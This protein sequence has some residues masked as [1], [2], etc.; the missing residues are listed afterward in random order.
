M[1]IV[2]DCI[3]LDPARG[4][5][6]RASVGRGLLLAGCSSLTLMF[7]LFSSSNAQA[8]CRW[9]GGTGSWFDASKWDDEPGRPCSGVPTSSDWVEIDRA[10]SNITIEGGQA[11]DH[12][13]HFRGG[14]VSIVNGGVLNSN[15]SY[16]LVGQGSDRQAELVVSGADSAWNVLGEAWVGRTA[17]GK[18]RLTDGGLLNFIGGDTLV[19][20]YT[21]TMQSPSH[22]VLVIGSDADANPA[23]P[24][25]VV[26]PRVEMG[27]GD[28]GGRNAT[29]LIVF[30]HTDDGGAYIFA[31]D[32]AGTGDIEHHAGATTLTGA[33][34]YDG[35]FDIAGGTVTFRGDG[36]N[37]YTGTTTV[38][39]GAVLN[40]DK[41]DDTIAISGPVLID[42]GSVNANARN[43]F[44][45]AAII[46]LAS[47]GMFTVQNRQH[48]AG[49]EG[50]DT[51]AR[52][53][54]NE[55]LYLWDGSH[56]YAGRLEG[57]G[58]LFLRGGA[59]T[60]LGDAG[61]WAGQI[62][63]G[64]ALLGLGHERA[65]GERSLFIIGNATLQLAAD[66]MTINN[67]ITG[68][69]I[70]PALTFDSNGYDGVWSGVI[71]N[72][73]A[74]PGIRG[75]GLTKSGTGTLTLTNNNTYEGATIVTE[76]ALIV[77]GS[78]A[79]SSLV[80]VNSGARLGGSG[81]V[82]TTIVSD[83]G[84]LAPGSSIGTLTVDG[85][86]TLSAGSIMD[87]EMGRAGS[88]PLSGVSD[89]IDVTG[90]L[91]LNGTLD[92][93]QSSDP[94]DG[95][96]GLGYYRLM[97]YGGALSGNGLSIG[98]TPTFADPSIYEIQAGGGNV[99]LF[100]A[101]AGDDALQH[102]QGG[103]GIWNG[104]NTKWLNQGGEAPVAWAGN[105][106]VF[107]NQPGGF[108]GGSIAVEGDQSFKGLQFVDEGYRLEGDG[109]L[110]VDGSDSD[111][112][113]AEIRVLADSAEIATEITG[114]GGISKTQAGT[115][116][117]SGQNTYQGDTSILGGTVQVSEDAN[118]GAASGGL[119][120]NGGTL[121]TVADMDSARSVML[122]GTGGFD[123]ASATTLGLTGVI[124][125][126]GDFLKRGGGTLVLTGANSYGGK[127][128][129]EAGTLVG[130]AASIRGNIG[131]AATLLF[132]QNGNASFAGDIGGLGGANGRMVKR[133]GGE[134]TLDG[135]STLDWTIEA[136]GLISAADRFGGN[137]EIGT[138]GAF[139]FDQKNNA[140]YAG[141]LSG[142]G[143]FTKDGSGVLLLSGDSSGF[144]GTTTIVGGT[145]LLGDADG[146]GAL[147]GSLD[148]LDDATLGGSGAFGS[149][150]GS[151]IT[152]ASG[153]TLA[154]GNSIGT[155]TVN[156]DLVFEAGSRFAVEV[157]PAGTDSDLVEVTGTATLD[158]GGVT[159]IGANGNYDLRSSYTILSAAELDG[160]FE[161]VT[162]DF[163]FLDPHLI[164]DYDAGTVGLELARNERD[165][166]S[167]A[168]TRNQIATAE[169][170]ESIGLSAGHG[171]YD[172]IA[173]L[174][175]DDDLIR[176]SF[177]ALSGEIHA[178]A[179]TALIE[180][181]RFVRNAA[182][183]RIRAAFAT[184]GASQAPVLAYGPGSTPVPVA[185][186][187][188]GPVFWSQGFGSWGT[189]DSDG[190]AA[191]LNHSVGGL[192]IGADGLVEDW[193]V[194]VLGGYS[195]SNFDASDRAS[196]G[197]SS[198]YHLGLYGGTQW[199]NLDFRTGAAYSW[200]NIET[201]RSVTIP[202]LTDSLSADYKAGMFQAF[203]ELG[204]GLDIGTE[205]RLEPF[206][207]L[208]HVSLHTDGFTEQGGAAVLTGSN[209]TTDVTSTTLGLRAEH[210]VML[211]TVNASLRGMIGWRHAFGDTRPEI[212]QAFS[213]GDAFTI[214][215]VPIA[216]NSAI[217]EGGLWLSLTP[218]ATF[219]LSYH[220]QIAPD[221]QDHG[222]KADLSLSF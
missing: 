162:S 127:T 16:H 95:T 10:D 22:G 112:G 174:A 140:R 86:L 30:N 172:A 48:I 7:M 106:A 179:Q 207:N 31:P 219:G 116:I 145:L 74:E 166:A 130:N 136:G 47:G 144:A 28:D 18:I 163:A 14:R 65:L 212:T 108:D 34:A 171:V 220:G 62:E 201:N 194:G 59:H 216:R 89:R 52:A 94:T 134:L 46:T 27:W 182:N 13:F 142:A 58:R 158:G 164:Y 170:V 200:H 32:V 44:D 180:D 80:T 126:T 151:L 211:G 99:D 66:G 49:L 143:S 157:N 102:W 165:F 111:D 202:G 186:D 183:D 204:Y 188:A 195:H 148:V 38:S 67:R 159:H 101:A 119:T 122:S 128:L 19:L 193:R 114:T 33:L 125:G 23:A 214:A 3:N 156:G 36:A 117:L 69:G 77:N 149:G 37:T 213:A 55:Q 154:P 40:L 167:V 221:A 161:D 152:V 191:N 109:R 72:G 150:S 175:D 168:L 60:F 63:V 187:H 203:G 120:F 61:T 87:Y 153:G 45:R 115:L 208:A 1:R 8:D 133:G 91:D 181:S 176:A 129:V 206:A 96:A 190:N 79:R 26:T 12:S 56:S 222:F 198:N 138:K 4:K 141:V 81:I 173:Q 177:D 11:Y 53:V 209:G 70:G 6:T 131:N 135:N 90:D 78:I 189:T 169:G 25:R 35:D 139:T 83:G 104:T 137:V 75:L 88:D 50:T 146:S 199:G 29:G 41:D 2:T 85:N 205:T 82:G 92:L 15:S 197:S 17:A 218:G 103:D 39:A 215:G 196:S 192:L 64:N 98:S 155:L 184:T 24:G 93:A 43:Q 76:G 210:N 123:V 121:A 147:G 54:L 84:I 132:D 9:S 42:G 71:S 100:I 51:T 185:A 217:I 57:A 21:T 5:V 118:L 73:T 178:S 107:K 113:N 97:T 124:E 68:V 105:H 20:G 110:V 160:K